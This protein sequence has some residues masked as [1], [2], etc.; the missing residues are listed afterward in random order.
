MIYPYLLVEK[1]RCLLAHDEQVE[2]QFNP[3]AFNMQSYTF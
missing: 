1:I 2:L 3:R